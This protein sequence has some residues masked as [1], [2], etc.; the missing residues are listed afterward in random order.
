MKNNG[1]TINL[2]Y[3]F[4]KSVD[5]LIK[6]VDNK[7]KYLHITKDSCFVENLQTKATLLHKF[8]VNIV[9]DY[10]SIKK[11]IYNLDKND[12]LFFET[13]NMHL[14]YPDLYLIVNKERI[15]NLKHQTERF[16]KPKE[17]FSIAFEKNTHYVGAL[18]PSDIELLIK[19]EDFTCSSDL[20]PVMNC[21][22]IDEYISAT[23]G[24]KL[25]FVKTNSSLKTVKITERIIDMYSTDIK[26]KEFSYNQS[27][28]INPVVLKILKSYNKS[29]FNVFIGFLMSEH[30][31]L[32]SKKNL[33]KVDKLSAKL[34]SENITIEFDIPGKFPNWKSIVPNFNKQD[35]PF[36][37][38]FINR[39]EFITALKIAKVSNPD[40]VL[41]NFNDESSIVELSSIDYD[42]NTITKKSFKYNDMTHHPFNDTYSE[43][44]EIGFSYSKMI[45]MLINSKEKE[46][47]IKLSKL[48]KAMVIDNMYL[49]M[50]LTSNQ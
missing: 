24:H 17:L 12:I 42:K 3:D 35:S 45:S 48:N 36:K 1:I 34:V 27:V 11:M 10:F 7:Q 40:N 44:K 29:T 25:S 2:F 14:L 8:G 39:A 43:I 22:C 28:L 4:I 9:V 15:M 37:E 26:F 19:Q 6:K 30:D 23:D 38:Y 20:R 41:M 33:I 47:S 18:I 21:I 13:D 5:K 31:V 32:N 46:F 49:L 50:P 16:M